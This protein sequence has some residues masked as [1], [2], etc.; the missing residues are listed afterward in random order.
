M[1]ESNQNYGWKRHRGGKCPVEAGVLIDV[2]HRDGDIFERV[3]VGKSFA[4]E[5]WSHGGDGG[6][7]MAYRLH[8]PGHESEKIPSKCQGRECEMPDSDD[9][10]DE[11]LLDAAIDQGWA[12]PLSWRDRIHEIDASSKE[13]EARHC[14]AMEAFDKERAELVAK[15][16]DEGLALCARPSDVVVDMSNPKN[17]QDGDLVEC[18]SD[19]VESCETMVV[20]CKYKV[21]R[22]GDSI[23]VIDEDGDKMTAV[24]NSD[25]IRWHS[26]PTA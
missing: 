11:C 7:I 9:H 2:R 10:S 5:D 14:A 26:R 4:C 1:T 20:G 6:D 17:W 25:R 15:L 12:G 24:V 16:A 18:V 19:K 21:A 13:E 23:G 3:R 8:K 22:D